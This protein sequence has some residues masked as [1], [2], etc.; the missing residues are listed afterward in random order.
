MPAD[1]A[2]MPGHQCGRGD[3]PMPPQL[4]WKGADQGGEHGP[5]RPG[6]ARPADLAPQHGDLMAQYQQLGHHRR[7]AP[8][9]L[10]QPAEHPNRAPVQQP[11]KHALDP[12]P[13]AKRELTPC[14]TVLAPYRSC[15]YP[16]HRCYGA[17]RPTPATRRLCGRPCL[18]AH[19]TD[20]RDRPWPPGTA[21]AAKLEPDPKR[22]PT[23]RD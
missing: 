7:I 5:V 21:H 23:R 9:H 22:T 12:A 6:Q 15:R 8:C 19:G 11:N 20:A 16:A 13:A 3:D 4:T 14:A 2:P 18:T 17:P 10:R 1:Q